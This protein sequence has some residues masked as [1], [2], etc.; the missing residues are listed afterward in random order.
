MIRR[1][2]AAATALLVLLTT[3]CT[4]AG[5]PAP[6][7]DGKGRLRIAVNGV[8]T[9]AQGRVT[10]SGGGAVW[11]LS[12]S[13]DL[14]VAPGRYKV[15]T[16]PVRGR[17]TTHHGVPEEQEVLVEPARTVDV[18][19]SY[20]LSIPDTTKLVEDPNRS[21]IRSVSG[22][23][24]VVARG[25][26]ARALRPGDVI[27]AGQGPGTPDGLC[28]KVVSIR[29]RGVGAIEAVTM[30]ARLYEALPDAKLTFERVAGGARAAG[31]GPS[32]KHSIEFGK[33]IGPV[34]PKVY[35]KG[36]IALDWGGSYIEWRD[37]GDYVEAVLS[38]RITDTEELGYEVA[39][40]F[41]SAEFIED[42]PLKS[43]LS[44]GNS[45]AIRLAK[46]AIVNVDC[47]L[48]GVWGLE[49]KLQGAL[50][51]AWKTSTVVDR[52]V[53]WRSD[54]P[55]QYEISGPTT[56]GKPPRYVPELSAE[57]SYAWQ[58]GLKFGVTGGA[59]VADLGVGLD[60]VFKGTASAEAT[61]PG[62]TGPAAGEGTVD[63]SIEV[64]ATLDLRFLLGLLKAP[65]FHA[66]L[67]TASLKTW[68]FPIKWLNT[69]VPGYSHAQ[70]DRAL[71]A[72]QRGVLLNGY[73][74]VSSGAECPDPR[75]AC[76]FTTAHGGRTNGFSAVASPN[77]LVTLHGTA[78]P[79]EQ[80]AKAAAARAAREL[81][82]AIGAGRFDIPPSEV[83]TLDPDGRLRKIRAYYGA[84]G[85]GTVLTGI[86][87]ADWT[88]DG[89]LRQYQDVPTARVREELKNRGCTTRLLAI[90]R[91]CVWPASWQDNWMVVTKHNVVLKGRFR[92][93]G[94]DTAKNTQY[95]TRLT[96]IME[97]FAHQIQEPTGA[98]GY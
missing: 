98:A 11:D 57:G 79:S 49:A 85:A 50:A 66:D 96:L 59:K 97:D 7:P 90:L 77:E 51:G 12:A 23:R 64:G 24:V 39:A 91:G 31:S 30:P 88:G 25:A 61:R 87:A 65:T 60:V 16:E 89:I 4:D 53:R 92:Q 95:L 81:S 32:S 40:R 46:K 94:A 48:T 6:V 13:G 14:D 2:A 33:R 63:I 3:A 38:P 27:L 36:E 72:V 10:V 82:A 47:G 43:P 20:R 80:A 19:A 18:D 76:E 45:W 37:D 55:G 78:Y 1:R 75:Q 56:I 70:V 26:Y 93:P 69:R 35:M 83:R 9:G 62:A 86:R 54:R 74:P 41:A 22:D 17:D 71:K 5:D 15:V 84:R 58:A 68:E 28:A 8:P 67:W 44:C 52:T 73:R 42:K 29:P 34:E 21:P